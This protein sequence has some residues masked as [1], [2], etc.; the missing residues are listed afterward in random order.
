MTGRITRVEIREIRRETPTVRSFTLDLGEQEFTFLPGQ[1]VDCYLDAEGERGVAGYTITSSPT[2]KRTIDLT[3]RERGENPVTRFLHEEAGV[4][5]VLYVDGGQGE[6][7]YSREMGDPLVLIAGGIGMTPLMSILRY[8]HD[9]APDVHAQLY[10]S[11]RTPSE[12]IFRGELEEIS[13]ARNRISCVFT[14]TRTEDEAWEGRR[15]RITSETLEAVDRDALFY[16]C[17]PPPMGQDMT[18]LLLEL[19]ARRDRIRYEQWW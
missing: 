6:F 11:A 5:D 2:T 16:I 15:G 19:G 10:Y 7:Y 3:V 13:R 17:G 9:G 4:G 8:V 1:W 18:E 14:V 12:I